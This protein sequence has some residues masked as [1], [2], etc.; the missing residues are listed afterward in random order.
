MVW[1]ARPGEVIIRIRM[2][3]VA[4]AAAVAVGVIT[5]VVIMHPY[6]SLDAQLEDD[7]EATNWGPLT[8]TFPFFT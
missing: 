3:A 5:A 1:W 4:I 6:L 8:L 2:F 7:I